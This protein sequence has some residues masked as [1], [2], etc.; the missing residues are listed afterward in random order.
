MTIGNSESLLDR[1]RERRSPGKPLG[2]LCLHNKP[3]LA[4]EAKEA[5][6]AL[7]H[8]AEVYIDCHEVDLKVLGCPVQSIV[9]TVEA[10]VAELILIG[11]ELDGEIPEHWVKWLTGWKSQLVVV[12]GCLVVFGRNLPESNARIS[13]YFEEI[14]KDADLDIWF[15]L[16][17]RVSSP[18]SGW[19]GKENP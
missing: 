13:G 1:L 16:Q 19:V 7:E 9:A 18:Q 6:R 5:K 3:S 8:D 10:E 2:A 11:I 17:D 12:K 14:A 4:A 15:A